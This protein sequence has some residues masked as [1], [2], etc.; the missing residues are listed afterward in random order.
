MLLLSCSLDRDKF[1][2]PN[3][4][5]WTTHLELG[6]SKQ[7]M[8][9]DEIMADIEDSSIIKIV[10]PEITNGDSTLY[11]F[12]DT[13]VEDLEPISLDDTGVK[14]FNDAITSQLGPIELSPIPKTVA[15]PFKLGEI[16][17]SGHPHIFYNFLRVFIPLNG[18]F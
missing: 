11:A 10:F 8:S 7:S 16:K 4:P 5:Y 15:P 2:N 14:S 12:Q 1:T 9:V 17:G 6:L 18:L 3:L 13:I